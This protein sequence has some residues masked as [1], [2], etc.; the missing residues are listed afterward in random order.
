MILI[1]YFV[2]MTKQLALLILFYFVVFQ[3]IAQDNR[4]LLS[5]RITSDT[6]VE[7][8]HILNKT[9]D[10]GT[11]SNT[12]GEFKIYVKEN[13]TLIFSGIQFYYKEVPITKQ[14]YTSRLLIVELFQRLNQLDEVEV[15]M[16]DLS[17]NLALDSE[18]IKDSTSKVGGSALDFSMID[19]SKPVLLDIDKMSSIQAPDA[20]KLTNPHI[21]V[22]G[23]VLGLLGLALDPLINELDKIGEHRRKRKL[24]ERIYEQKVKDAPENIITYLGEPFFIETLKIPREEIN[25]FITYCNPKGITALYVKNRKIELIDILITESNKYLKKRKK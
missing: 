11:I 17:G 4:V 6:S 13:D 5:G 10:K 20:E 22:G 23:N 9:S 16:H 12:H 15:K 18:K 2:S 14:Q 8:I 19:F 7:N 24:K 21:P 3:A 25:D 1:T